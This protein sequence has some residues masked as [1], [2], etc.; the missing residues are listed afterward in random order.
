MEKCI[1]AYAPQ[2]YAVMRIV[3][4]L[5]FICHGAQKV[6]GLFGGVNGAP[7]PFF[8]IF[9]IA[10]FVESLGGLLIVV[11]LFTG[12]AAFVASG[13]M[14]VAYFMGH[15][16][17]G[18]WPIQ[19]GGELAVLNCFIF[20]YMATRGAG[21]WSLDEALNSDPRRSSSGGV[22]WQGAK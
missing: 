11:G 20:L 21:I 7:A 22:E 13:E 19:N 5:L 8:S 2:A 12:Y 16:P 10:G 6:F 1:G 17:Q 18:F 4:G 3:A 15:F 9:G 14:A